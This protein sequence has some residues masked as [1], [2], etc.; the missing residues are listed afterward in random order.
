MT[1]RNKISSILDMMDELQ[2][3]LLFLPDD[4]L[5]SIDLLQLKN[6]FLKG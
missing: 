2:D 1:N 6:V 4:M 3:K 5:L